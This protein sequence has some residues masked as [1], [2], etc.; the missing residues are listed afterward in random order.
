MTQLDILRPETK[1]LTVS[2]GDIFA[3]GRHRLMCGD[4][5][6]KAQV[7]QL[8][9]G[10][11]PALVVTSPPYK[12][13]RDYHHAIVCWDALMLNAL[14]QET[15]ADDV[16]LLIN[17]GVVHRKAEIL[18]YWDDWVQSMRSRGW[19]QAGIYVW[20]KLQA[21]PGANIG[22]PRPAHEF[23]FHLRKERLKIND[24][25]ANKDAGKINWGYKFRDADGTLRVKNKKRKPIKAAK[26]IDSVLRIR[27]EKNNRTGHPAVF[28]IHLPRKLIAAYKGNERI[29][30]DPFL[31]SGTTLLAC[32]AENVTGLGME[33]SPAY[34]TIAINRWNKAHPDQTAYRVS[35]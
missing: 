4:A 22:T 18:C 1:P 25:E 2:P 32:E 31:G 15:F 17:L 23:I 34:C 21:V 13:I 8:F 26:P 12:D 24:T 6:D 19:K 28:P 30:Y 16:Q 10:Q 29:T 20:D 9:A 14:D 35:P 3:L 5:T 27:A 33:I 7:A 11:R